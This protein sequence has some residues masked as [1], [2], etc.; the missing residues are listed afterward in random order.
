MK[1]FREIL[2]ALHFLLFSLAALSWFL[3]SAWIASRTVSLETAPCLGHP[4]SESGLDM[5]AHLNHLDS[6]S[7]L[8]F[9]CLVKSKDRCMLSSLQPWIALA[10]RLRWA[11][12]KKVI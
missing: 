2:L 9:T 7:V 3:V 1:M 12:W 4:R 6:F 11:A 10:S 5:A 8:V